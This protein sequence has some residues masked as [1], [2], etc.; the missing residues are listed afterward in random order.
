VGA[1]NALNIEKREDTGNNSK[2]GE[3]YHPVREIFDTAFELEEEVTDREK[4]GSSIQGDR[5]RFRLSRGGRKTSIR[6]GGRLSATGLRPSVGR[7]K[8]G[9]GKTAGS[10]NDQS[11]ET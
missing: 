8:V 1:R 5:L 7:E 3:A 4:E 6:K 10:A 2:G 9:T 11:L